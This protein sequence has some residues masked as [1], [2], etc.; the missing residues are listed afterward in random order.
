VELSSKS[1]LRLRRCILAKSKSARPS[2]C[3]THGKY[4]ETGNGEISDASHDKLFSGQLPTT[5][6]EELVDN[7]AYNGSREK[8]PF[9][10][11]HYSLSEIAVY[12]DG[13]RH[14]LKPLKL[15]FE[16]GSGRYVVAY[17]SLFGGT[18]K[19]NGDDDNDV[20]RSDYG[21]EYALFAYDLTPDLAELSHTEVDEV[22]RNR[23]VVFDFN[24]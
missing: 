13:Q 22:D 9:N 6:I 23:T 7:G 24:N 12:L 3:K 14:G 11:H 4:L 21:N 15:K 8:N 10:F 1:S 20:S 18:N 17:A 2:T 5:L 16:F 19:I